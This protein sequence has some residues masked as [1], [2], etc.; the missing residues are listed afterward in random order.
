MTSPQAELKLF[1]QRR[2]EEGWA[3][4]FAAAITDAQATRLAVYEGETAATLNGERVGIGP[5]T[6]FNIGSVTKPVTAMLLAKLVEAGEL[7][8]ADKV[9][10]IIPEYPFEDA[11]LFH[12]L[13][14]SAG[15]DNDSAKPERPLVQDG[16]AGRRAYFDAICRIPDRKREP[17]QS[18][19]Y[20]TEGYVIL[21]DVIE[22]VAGMEL[23]RFAHETLFQPLGMT[24]S[25]FDV[26]AAREDSVVFPIAPDG[27]V[28]LELADWATT[29]D[30]G[31]YTCAEDLLK[32]G[33]LF[34]NGG[35]A[36]D[37]KAVLHERTVRWLLADA[38]AGRF[39]Q[40]PAFWVKG[41]EDRYGCFGD[42]HSPS[43]VG[44]TGFSGCMLWVD[45]EYG[46]AGAILTNST[47]LHEDWRRY[48][49]INNRLLS[50]ATGRSL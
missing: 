12:L 17:G 29:G 36:E 25:T 26:V 9:R 15:Y 31:L 7:T 46:A 18:V 6:L 28:M 41:A 13:S 8:L 14:H 5:D 38:S 47:R 10:S 34:L 3:E 48:K 27:R 45:P 39:N 35:A 22:R 30:S 40:T 32:L 37:G 44:H 19:L 42:L 20:Y 50:L 1:L 16:E 21:A 4:G 49:R 33:R 11:D 2:K 43:A 23:G 24:R